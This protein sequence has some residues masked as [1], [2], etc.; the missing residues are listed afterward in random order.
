MEKGK[1]YYSGRQGKV[2]KFEYLCIHSP[3]PDYHFLI[4]CRTSQPIKIYKD[5][6]NKFRLTE[7]DAVQEAIHYHESI[8]E[9]ILKTYAK[10]LGN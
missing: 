3:N 10:I 1:K 4:E 7:R 6:L 8:I 2:E 9:S 5:D